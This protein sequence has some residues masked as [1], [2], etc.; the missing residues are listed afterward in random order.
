MTNYV[1][2]T[3]KAYED[4]FDQYKAKNP[5]SGPSKSFME[6]FISLLQGEDILEVDFPKNSFDGIL[7]MASLLHLNNIDFERVIEKIYYWL[8]PGG[9]VFI[10]LKEGRKELIKSDS[11]YF[12]LFT[13]SRF[14][15]LIN[16]RL[17][18]EC[19]I[20]N[21]AKSYN[22]GKENWLTFYLRKNG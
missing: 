2:Q 19:F 14:L 11:R 1:A 20:K 7:A 16:N 18:L 12:N 17:K 3:I 4:I 22:R 6:K 9:V 13:K 5:A 15:K 21:K 10:S 8:K